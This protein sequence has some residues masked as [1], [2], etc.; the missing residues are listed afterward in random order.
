[1]IENDRT[2]IADMVRTFGREARVSNVVLLDR[3][4]I[5]RHS[6]GPVAADELRR[7]SPTCQACHHLPPEQRGSSQVIERGGGAVLRT[8]I[9][10]RNREAC[11]GCHDPA[12]RVNG[13]MILDLDVGAVRA[14]TNSE[15][16]WM[17]AG[18]GGFALLLIVAIAVIVRV[19]VLKR[20][21]RFETTARQIAGGDLDKRVPAEGSDTVSWLAREFN[22]MADS[23]TGLLSE[24]RAQRERLENVINSIDDGIVVLDRGRRVVAANDAFVQRTAAPRER[25]LGCACGEVAPGRCAVPECP[26]LACLA[27][28]QRQVRLCESRRPDGSVTWEEVHASPVRGPSGDI[29]QVVEVWR[30]ISERRAADA[31][32]AESHRLGSLG[33]LASGYSHE[34]N[35]PLGTVL[36]CVEGIL[37]ET[38]DGQRADLDRS[39]VAEHAGIARDQVLRCRAITQHFLRL[40][41]GQRSASDLVDVRDT[42][43]GVARL[44]APTARAESVR[45]T[46]PDDGPAV[47]I[48]ADDADLQHALMN[49]LL[50]AVQA[51]AS[52][53][54]V[55]IELA[56]GPPV[57]VRIADDGCGIAPGDRQRIF[58][59]FVGLRRGGT[60]L[61]LFLALNFVKRWGG[62]I[63]VTGEA[64]CGAVFDLTFPPA[65]ADPRHEAAS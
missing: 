39:R 17:V 62:D 31:R 29:T 45:I 36:M 13:I 11:H 10:F 2:L 43:A 18:S 19:V 51:C 64:G 20:L 40:S 46:G 41:R 16:R 34:M 26:T 28:G 27:S 9:P 33:L 22:T 48:R 24:V 57:R 14:S 55:A 5:V 60:G 53:G 3:R 61:G 38:A 7:D 63:A 56:A 32:L 6:S 23:V 50:N 1:M 37:R 59:P 52:G 49:V 47:L 54:H 21:Q 25:V 44:I 12:Q 8:V 30:D 4:G 65:V 58:E 42:L 15:L 35:T